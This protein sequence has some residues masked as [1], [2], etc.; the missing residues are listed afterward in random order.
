MFSKSCV[1]F[2]IILQIT[3]EPDQRVIT[4]LKYSN[5]YVQPTIV[6][7]EPAISGQIP[8][9]VSIKE[10]VKRIGRDRTIWKNLCGG[11]IIGKTKVLTAAHC[12][13]GRKFFYARNSFYLRI[14]AGNLRN[15]VTHSGKTETNVINQWRNISKV[16]IHKHFH[17]P[18]NDL[19][20][21]FV[22]EKFKF[23]SNVDYIVT[24]S[25]NLDYTRSCIAAGYGRTGFTWKDP[26]SP[27][28][29][30]ARIDTM[31][32][33]RCSR[34]WEM[35]M[36]TFVCS[37]SAFSDVSRGDSGGPLACKG[38]PDPKEESNRDLLVGV[39]SGKNFDKTTLYTRVSAYH[40][41][42]ASGKAHTLLNN[43]DFIIILTLLI[44]E[45]RTGD[46]FSIAYKQN[47]RFI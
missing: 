5:Y 16:V 40:D 42:I 19:A 14:V 39:V 10:P 8:Y 37:A 29:L 47:S 32:K 30:I 36:N 34:V 15:D 11:S 33:W 23:R 1:I 26:I 31:P 41:W 21:V 17:F 46:K 25:K 3:C 28:L 13:E 4:T 44:Y 35:N 45:Y 12:F 7:G 24:A 27:V 20:L 43:L 2:H 38:T 18:N 9:L 6:N 22:S